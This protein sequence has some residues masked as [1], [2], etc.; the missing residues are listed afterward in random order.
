MLRGLSQGLGGGLCLC[1]FLP[2]KEWPQK[3]H[4][5][6]FGTHPVPGQSR[7][8]VY[9]YVFF[10]SLRWTPKPERGYQKRNDGT[11]SRNEGTFAKTALVFLSRGFAYFQK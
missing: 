6:D 8:F 1:V 9:I 10:L 11:K 2:H 7:K 4:K 5:P 3:T